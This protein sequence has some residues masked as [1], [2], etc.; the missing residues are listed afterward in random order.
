MKPI[1][2]AHDEQVF[3]IKS[4]IACPVQQKD[5]SW[6]VVLKKFEED[7]PDKGRHLLI[8]NKCGVSTYPDC[9]T[10]CQIEKSWCKSIEQVIEGRE[11]P[12][13]ILH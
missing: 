4:S 2:N 8:C 11:R 9:I 13:S 1:K 3:H 12:A 7:I 5:G 10:S 6:K